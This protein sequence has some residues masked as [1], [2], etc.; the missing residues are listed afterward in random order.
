M[1][2]YVHNANIDLYRRLIAESERN[3][4]R[5]ENR[6]KMLLTLLGEELAKD[7]KAKSGFFPPKPLDYRMLLSRRPREHPTNFAIGRA[8]PLKTE[9]TR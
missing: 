9:T 3:P 7:K 2:D 4:K 1:L 8:T 6:H 5:D